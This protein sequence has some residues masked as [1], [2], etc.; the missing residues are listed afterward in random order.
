VLRVGLRKPQAG[1]RLD[2]DGQQVQALADADDGVGY[3][4]PAR[5]RQQHDGRHQAQRERRG[6]QQPDQG[7]Q[8]GQAAGLGLHQHLAAGVEVQRHLA[9][10]QHR[11]QALLQL[12]LTLALGIVDAPA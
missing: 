11:C 8:P 7:A 9:L 4:A 3:V 2:A 6:G 5:L 1:K 12:L 10:G